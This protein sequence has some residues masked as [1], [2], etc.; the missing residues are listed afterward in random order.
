MGVWPWAHGARS[1]H[2]GGRYTNEISNNYC[3]IHNKTDYPPHLFAIADNAFQSMARN[4]RPQVCVISGESGAGKTE[5]AKQFIRQIMDVS[6]KGLMGAQNSAG[7][8]RARHPRGR[9][10]WPGRF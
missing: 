8:E 7:Q 10:R 3:N 9:A 2:C 4:G 1:A 6:A 5:S